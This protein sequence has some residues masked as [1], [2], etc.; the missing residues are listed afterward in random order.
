MVFRLELKQEDI[1]ELGCDKSC[2]GHWCMGLSF[3]FHFLPKFTLIITHTNLHK[4][5]TF[6]LGE[7]CAW[8]G[9]AG[10]GWLRV[11]L[12]LCFGQNL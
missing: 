11:N 10:V 6:V 2:L 8:V 4:P 3:Y 7:K 1:I 12:M 9:G 5:R